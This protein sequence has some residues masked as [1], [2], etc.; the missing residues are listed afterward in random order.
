MVDYCLV[1][2]DELMNIHNFVVIVRKV[3]G[4]L[5]TL[6]SCGI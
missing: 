2:E 6:S 1:P 4:C 3:I 5:I